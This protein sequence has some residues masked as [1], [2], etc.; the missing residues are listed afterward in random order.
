MAPKVKT[1]GSPRPPEL[2]AQRDAPLSTRKR[3]LGDGAGKARG[4]DVSRVDENGE[5]PR[6]PEVAQSKDLET[7]ALLPVKN[8][9]FN[10]VAIG[11]SAH[12][13]VL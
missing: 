2:A 3:W 7:F 11:E 5:A 6:Y 13:C 10:S 9:R 4:R 8:V 1:T 12:C